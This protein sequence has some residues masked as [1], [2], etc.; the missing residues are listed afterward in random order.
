MRHAPYA[1]FF[2]FFPLAACRP[3][4]PLCQQRQRQR[5]RSQN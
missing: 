1:R 4:L 2:F 3:W 5:Q